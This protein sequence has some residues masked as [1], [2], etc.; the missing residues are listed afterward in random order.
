MGRHRDK[1]RQSDVELLSEQDRRAIIIDGDAGLLVRR[2]E[3]IGSELKGLGLKSAQIRNV[4]G[5]VRQIQ[6]SWPPHANGD[7][8][9]HA[10]RQ[11]Q[12]LKPKLKY[13]AARNQREVGPLADILVPAIDDI[14]DERYRFQN[15]VDFFEAILAYHRAAGGN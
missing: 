6:M 4:F 8:Q 10:Y 11:L 7:A 5:T 13:Q 9:Q 15:F 12:L 14:G 3:E 1:R 2:A